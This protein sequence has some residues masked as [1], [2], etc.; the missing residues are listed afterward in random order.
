MRR[1]PLILPL[2]QFIGVIPTKLDSFLNGNFPNSGNMDS[3]V[4]AVTLPTPGTLVS[5]SYCLFQSSLSLR[6]WSIHP[7]LL[8]FVLAIQYEFVYLLW[9]S[10]YEHYVAVFTV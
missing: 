8:L 7:F 10:Y 6:S 5:N 1:L 3:N 4:T 2:P 9:H